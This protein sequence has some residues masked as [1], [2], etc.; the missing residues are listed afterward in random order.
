[1]KN[2]EPSASALRQESASRTLAVDRLAHMPHQP[3]GPFPE[4]CATL[5]LRGRKAARDRKSSL[6]RRV[7]RRYSV[8]SPM[9]PASARSQLSCHRDRAARYLLA[10]TDLQ[11]TAKE[12]VS[13][14]LGPPGTPV[15]SKDRVTATERR[16][17]VPTRYAS[18]TSER[19]LHLC[20]T[21]STNPTQAQATPMLLF[22]IVS[23]LA[24]QKPTEQQHIENSI[25]VTFIFARADF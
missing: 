12:L 17:S 14:I 7:R 1:M 6:I 2:R 8:R 18:V 22:P 21:R 11:A 5:H 20:A 23:W 24:L 10:A 4:A 16:W 3:R 15:A 19:I 13:G 9:L 25:S